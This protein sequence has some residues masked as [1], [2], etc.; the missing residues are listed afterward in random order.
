MVC[1]TIHELYF[2]AIVKK[3]KGAAFRKD[4]L[5]QAHAD[6]NSSGTN[7]TRRFQLKDIEERCESVHDRCL[8]ASEK[9]KEALQSQIASHE[10][11]SSSRGALSSFWIT[12]EDDEGL[13]IRPHSS[14]ARL[15]GP[16]RSKPSMQRPKSQ[17][18][19]RR[20]LNSA[21]PGKQSVI[22]DN[23]VCANEW[24]SECSPKV[25]LL[26]AEKEPWVQQREAERRRWQAHKRP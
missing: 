3:Q 2:P 6:L 19:P 22:R 13:P 15:Q 18:S 16:S 9:L 10:P 1:D 7:Q 21:E 23:T 17:Q 14:S 12:N 5:Y 8:S 26:D 24:I 20:L 11:L 25:W 4:A